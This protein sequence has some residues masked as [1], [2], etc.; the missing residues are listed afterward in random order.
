[1]RFSPTNETFV[2]EF[3]ACVSYDIPY[4]ESVLMIPSLDSL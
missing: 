2:G 1:M 3:F 4:N